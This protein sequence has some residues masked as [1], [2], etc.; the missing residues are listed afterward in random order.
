MIHILLY[1][2]HICILHRF[3]REYLERIRLELVEDGID[4][5]TRYF[6][7]GYAEHMSEYLAQPDSEEPDIMVSADL[8]VFEDRRIYGRF[9][10]NLYDVANWIEKRSLPSLCNALRGDD[11]L[12]ILSIPLV[13]F[14]RNPEDCRRTSITG[15]KGLSIGGVD[16]SAIKSIVK[17]IWSHRG[18]QAAEQFL[19][20][21]TVRDMPIEAFQDVVSRKSETALVPSI[22]ALR[23]DNE[24]TFTVVPREGAILV[25]SYLAAAR[26]APEWAVRKVVEKIISKELADFYVESGDLI[27]YP[28]VTSKNTRTILEKTTAPAYNWLE[29]Y[30]P[31]EFYKLYTRMLP[32][33]RDFFRR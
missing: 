12:P 3:E 11:L 21:C 1:W 7:L 30:S 24:N 18:K 28:A 29:S 6:G 16:N 10:S 17:T 23:S 5:E 13:Y 26:K 32:M 14:T 22:Y 27:F 15:I 2:N 9:S 19:E 25:N 33:A 20:G 4:L 8:E 31:E